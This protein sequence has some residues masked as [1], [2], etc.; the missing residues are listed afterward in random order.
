MISGGAKIC[1]AK[2]GVAS[3]SS[4]FVAME[5]MSAAFSRFYR[6]VALTFC[7]VLVQALVATAGQLALNNVARVS[8]G[9][10]VDDKI[11]EAALIS[12][13]P[14]VGY[15]LVDGQTELVLS[16]SKIENI[17]IV[18]FLN[19]GTKGTVI[20]ATSN[21]KLA[22]GSLQWHQIAKQDLTANVTKINLGPTEAK[23][24]KFTFNVAKS[25][26]I[27]E[28]AVYSTTKLTLANT[29]LVDG[30]DA[31]DF[32][33]GKEAKEVAEGP[34][35]EGPPPNLP[36]PPSFVFVPIVSP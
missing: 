12:G 20:V 5:I 28:L 16:L 15:A 1:I 6:I 7:L 10:R 19:N 14:G 3:L 27:A 31:K 8:I 24:M 18:S 36:D 30:K 33:G 9:A 4:F 32:G 25:G 22:T 11:A 23:Y 17:D 26:R 34:P 29:D 13:Q 2:K 21:S 35:E